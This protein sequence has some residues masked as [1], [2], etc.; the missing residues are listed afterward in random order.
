MFQYLYSFDDRLITNFRESPDGA[1]NRQIGKNTDCKENETV[2]YVDHIWQCNWY[3]MYLTAYRDRTGVDDS[4][5][6]HSAYDD[7]GTEN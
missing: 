6:L 5:C 2:W 3:M 4:G 1:F 7:L